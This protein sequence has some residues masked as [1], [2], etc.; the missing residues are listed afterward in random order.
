[1]TCRHHL[2]VARYPDLA[3]LERIAAMARPRQIV[4]S[5]IAIQMSRHHMVN[6]ESLTSAIL[7]DI[8]VALLHESPLCQR[9]SVWVAAMNE[10]ENVQ[11]NA[12]HEA[13]KLTGNLSFEAPRHRRS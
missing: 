11:I 6:V 12:A 9:D 5:S 8:P 7:A 1:M 2:E 13:P 10:R 3:S 4:C